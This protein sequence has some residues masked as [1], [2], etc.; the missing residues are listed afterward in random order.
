MLLMLRL[1]IRL[2]EFW[3]LSQ[4]RKFNEHFISAFGAPKSLV[5]DCGPEFISSAM[6]KACEFHDVHLYHAAVEAPWVNGIAERGGQT[7]KT[8]CKAV[9]ARSCPIGSDDMTQVLASAIS[10]VNDDVG[11]SGFT[12]A[13]KTTSFN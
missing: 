13:G 8:I 7:L 4:Q 2:L 5:C 1:S 12:G 10:A 11:E 3:L 9:S 6:Q